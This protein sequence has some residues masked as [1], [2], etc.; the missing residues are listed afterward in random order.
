LPAP[1][2]VEILVYLVDLVINVERLVPT[3]E[4]LSV[5]VRIGYKFTS[6]L[7]VKRIQEAAISLACLVPGVSPFFVEAVINFL[8]I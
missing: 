2:I 5:N 3:L 4:R 6:V 8:A 7:V 1:E